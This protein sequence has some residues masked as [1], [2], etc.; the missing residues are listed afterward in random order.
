MEEMRDKYKEMLL[1]MARK[2]PAFYIF[3]KHCDIYY[4]PESGKEQIFGAEVQFNA[5]STIENGKMIIALF[6]QWFESE[7]SD[8]IKILLHELWHIINRHPLRMKSLIDIYKHKYQPV[9]SLKV[10]IN[11]AMDYKVDNHYIKAMKY[12]VDRALPNVLTQKDVDLLSIEEIFKKLLNQTKDACNSC[13]NSCP[14]KGEKGKCPL[15]TGDM[16]PLIDVEELK[17]QLQ[18]ATQLNKGTKLRGDKEQQI[19]KL[20]KDSLLAAKT[21]GATLTSLEE[22]ILEKLVKPKVN[23]K[24]LL[25][26]EI[27][28]WAGKNVINTWIRPSRKFG[29]SLPGI[30]RFGLPKIWSFIDVSGSINDKEFQQFISEVVAIFGSG[31]PKVVIVA[32]DTNVCNEYEVRK[33]AD[34]PKLQFRGGGGTT[35]TPIIQSYSNK[36]KNQDLIIVLTDGVWFDKEEAEKDINK[37]R[38]RKILVS[39]ENLDIK[40]FNS[41][42]RLEVC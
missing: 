18:N 19:Q 15:D 29:N 31:V 11:L 24:T 30:K 23:W 32:W 7:D 5:F 25:R 17:K 27:R 36:I 9:E 1:I 20:F 14:F 2:H 40:G 10:A 33:K 39:T 34:I 35:F 16:I 42:I 4:I 22:R 6:K 38:S 13:S 8:K 3:L 37:I 28:E 41:K 21:A 26:K 12:N